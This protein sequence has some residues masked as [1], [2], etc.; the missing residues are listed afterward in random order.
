MPLPSDAP[1]SRTL[2]SVEDDGLL[3][4]KKKKAEKK[5]DFLVT[6]KL[7]SAVKRSASIIPWRK[8]FR[9]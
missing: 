6:S 9:V 1:H 4:L 5:Q 2:S 3:W 7:V 8:E